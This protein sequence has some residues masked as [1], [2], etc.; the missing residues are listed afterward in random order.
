MTMQMRFWVGCDQAIMLVNFCA[1]PNNLIIVRQGLILLAVGASWGVC[2]SFL[3][4]LSLVFSFI[5][6]LSTAGYRLKKNKKTT[7]QPEV[8]MCEILQFCNI[9]F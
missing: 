4:P 3:L 9:T 8:S 7:N 5:L 6:S 1:S 2:I